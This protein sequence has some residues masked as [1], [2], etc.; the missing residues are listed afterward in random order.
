MTI[1]H[2]PFL[3]VDF[4]MTEGETEIV[5]AVRTNDGSKLT[6]QDALDGVLAAL[7][8]AYSDVVVTPLTKEQLEEDPELH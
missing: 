4:A 1:R 3:D 6:Q 8:E 5:I 7:E 2:D